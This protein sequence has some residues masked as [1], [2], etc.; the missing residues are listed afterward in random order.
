[1]TAHDKSLTDCAQRATAILAHDRSLLVEAGA[2]SGKTALMAGRIALMLASGVSP[3][4]IAAVTFTELA[5]SELLSRVRHVVLELLAG[6]IPKELKAILPEGLTERQE[7]CLEEANARIEEITC[8]TIHG[9]CQ[10]LIKPY[11]VEANIDPGA[12]VMGRD[13]A[14]QRFEELMDAWLRQH[15]SGKSNSLVAE[16]VLADPFQALEAIRRVAGCLRHGRPVGTRPA[17]DVQETVATFQSCVQAFRAFI[18]G[19]PAEESDTAACA[20]AFAGMA[21]SAD[22]ALAGEGSTTLVGLVTLKAHDKLCKADGDFAKYRNKTKWREAA[23][24]AGL[25]K[26]EG[27]RL[28]EEAERHHTAC[29]EAWRAMRSNAASHILEDLVGEIRPLVDRFRNYKRS[30]AVLDFDDLI[31]SARDL[32]RDHEPVRRALSTRY[33]HV[34][35][36]EFQDT[37]PLQ[38]EIFWRL[39]GN[40]PDG[41]LDAEWESFALRPGAL[42]LVGDPKQAIYRFRGADVSAYLRARDTIRAQSAEDVLSI[43]TNFRSYASILAFVNERFENILQGAGQPGFTRLDAFH[44]DHNRGACVAALHVAMT[45]AK[46][47]PSAEEQRDAEAEAVADLCHRLIGRQLVQDHATGEGRLCRPG[48]IALLAPSGTDLWRYEEA[49]ERHGIPVA[50]QAGKGFFRRQEVQ[51]LIALTRIL[52]DP[53][54][55][56]ALGAFLRGPAVGLTDEQLLDIVGELPRDPERPGELPALKLFLDPAR[57]AHP[58]ARLVL[59][60]LQALAKRAN[61]TTPH[62]LL[63]RA[64]DV[65][66]LRPI[67][68]QRHHGHAERA[69]ANVDLFLD[70]ARPYA[71]RG[72]E[73][74]GQ[75]MME[76]WEGQTR[77]LEGRP[78]AQEESVA[79]YTMHAAKGLEWPVVIPINT[80]TE[81][82]ERAGAI[83][84]RA[85][86]CLYCPVFGVH[87][88]GYDAVLVAERAEINRERVRIWYVA[89]TRARELLVLPRLGS[90]PPTKSWKAIVDLEIETLPEIEIAKLPPGRVLSSEEPENEQTRGRFA[91]EASRIHDQERR[92]QWTTPSLDEEGPSARMADGPEVLSGDDD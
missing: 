18:D 9:F 6:R 92:L 1:M 4:A 7:T 60:R 14:E 67:L 69:L 16:M 22:K 78:D 68:Q 20:S 38:T 49:L 84:D 65:L 5:A 23:K 74:F 81:V 56:L 48:D 59:E 55:T 46:D 79:L 19:S 34:L 45:S 77:A 71:V 15:L 44:P 21:C 25:P 75:A 53:R 52:A 24:H 61:S 58:L 39:C 89:A 83:I 28:N 91:V 72:L 3:S 17:A 64:V 73:A 31:F 66:H 47:K 13:E 88:L 76:A 33:A 62:D 50:T 57:V 12:S 85:A 8:T 26:N 11:P 42:F 29:C 40:P 30:T 27:E 63:S 54:D 51:D 90:D 37:D 10:R 36:D 2:G 70:L 41:R 86:N 43:S 80:T 82:P 87:P 32:L 35:V